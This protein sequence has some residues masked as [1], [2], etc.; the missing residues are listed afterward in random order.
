MATP[1]EGPYV[2]VTWI[3][4]LMAGEIHCEWAAWFRAHHKY[5]KLPSDFDLAQ[6][7][8]QHTEMVRRRAETLRSEGSEV[9]LESQN[10]FRL[11]GRDGTVLAGKPD[12]VALRDGGATVIDCKTG[13]PK[14]SDHIQVLIYMIVLP[15]THPDCRGRTLQGELQYT[16]ASVA[17]A[18]DGLTPEFRALFRET[19]HRVGARA[20]LPRA[21]SYAECRF[22]DI[23]SADCPERIETPAGAAPADHDLF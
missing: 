18:P 13:S 15:H 3:T 6:W 10:A 5:T 17:V 19:M 12:L 9:R 14:T 20:P 22:C 2:W 8:A 16:D 1:R 7:T 23:G 21:P 4:K 11:T